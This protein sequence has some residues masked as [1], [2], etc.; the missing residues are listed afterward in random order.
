MNQFIGYLMA[1]MKA[2][3]LGKS[4]VLQMLSGLE[5]ASASQDVLHPLVQ[6][7]TSDLTELRFSSRF[8][9]TEPYLEDHVVLGDPI[10]PAVCF[11]EMASKAASVTTGQESGSGCCV[12]LKNVT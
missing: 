9:G 2:G 5:G 3:R 6:R 4:E 1:E 8:D 10:L 7:N 11:L 12:E